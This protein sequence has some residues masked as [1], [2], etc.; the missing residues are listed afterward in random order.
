MGCAS[1]KADDLEA[2]KLCSERCDFLQEAIRQRY[3]FADAHVAYIHSL[4]GIGLSLQRVFDQDTDKSTSSPVLPLPT[5]RKGD[6][7]TFA[8]EPSS[9]PHPAAAIARDSNSNSGSHIEFHSD[10]E[11]EDHDDD[12]DSFGSLHHSG[13]A[14]PLHHHHHHPPQDFHPNYQLDQAPVASF[15]GGF[16]NMNYMRNRP[17]PSVSYEQRPMSPDVVRV[18]ASSSSYYPYSY[19]N[20]E[21]APDPFNSYSNYGGFFGSPPVTYGSSSSTPLHKAAPPSS[22][23]SSKPPPAPPPPP[24]DSAWDFFNPFDTLDRYNPPPYTPSRNSNEVREEE[25]IPDLEDEEHKHEDVKEVHFDQKFVGDSGTENYSKKV[26]DD[27]DERGNDDAEAALYQTRPSVSVEGV[28]Y[29]DVHMVDKNVI[30]NEERS[31]DQGNVAAFKARVRL[32]GASEVVAEIKIQFERAAESGSEV[33]RILEAGKLPYRKKKGV[34]QVSSKMLHVI[35]PSTSKSSEASSSIEKSGSAYL[36]FDEDAGTRSANLSSTLQKLYIWEK[37][38]Y[39][40]VK[41]EE[42]MR[43]FHDQKWK[44]LLRLDRKGAEAHKV[45]STQTLVRD[46]SAKIRIAIQVVDKIS[47]KITKLRDEELWPQLNEL[48][49]GLVRMWKVMLECHQ[50]QCQAITEAKNLDAIITSRKFGAALLEA[51]MQLEHEVLNWI[52]NFSSWIGAQKGYITALNRWLLKCIFDEPE[53]TP[54]GKP[55]FSPGRMGAPTVFVICHQWSQAMERISEKEVVDAML[56]FAVGLRQNIDLL[57]TLTTGDV[58]R[59][60]KGLEG[61]EQKM[62]KAIQALDKKIVMVS[63]KGTGV[64]V[65]EQLARQSDMRNISS[66]QSGLKQIFDAVERF[67]AN[68]MQAYEELCVRIEEEDRLARENAKVP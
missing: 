33:S 63:G 16:M 62:Q 66:L 22:S 45:E 34:Y 40:E 37:K 29:D 44:R 14:S 42:K 54:D 56:A 38:L 9:V 18:D 50:N 31:K 65:S 55:P 24:S 7:I 32:G 17:T 51:A 8:A 6:P 67:T 12:D 2:V 41:A 36:D 53:E 58:E 35:T 19:L 46:L 60:V 20:H 26:A 3:A 61:E 68:S 47:V 52:S 28:E 57:Q 4:K 15:P 49:H 13:H 30:A 1:S 11:D 48:I 25:G 43:V 64:L 59:K 5:Q 21:P 10:S 27:E 23:S 39:D